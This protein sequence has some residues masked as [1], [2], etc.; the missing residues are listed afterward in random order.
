MGRGVETRR[1]TTERWQSVASRPQEWGTGP[2]EKR[3]GVG[4]G[5]EG[6]RGGR[7]RAL[8]GQRLN[9]AIK[10]AN[11]RQELLSSLS[12]RARASERVEKS[13]EER[14]GDRVADC[15][16]AEAVL[17]MEE[18]RSRTQKCSRLYCAVEHSD[19]Q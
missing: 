9:C 8:G 16:P 2:G 12:E 15:R 17:V 5:W 7:A 18:L 6:K 11:V 19:V 1:P 3:R 10:L 13:R 14:R 4:M